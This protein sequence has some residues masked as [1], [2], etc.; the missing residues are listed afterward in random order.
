MPHQKK[1]VMHLNPSG[2]FTRLK[3]SKKSTAVAP[4]LLYQDESKHHT[5]KMLFLVGGLE[6]I[7]ENNA[8]SKFG[9]EKLVH[10]IGKFRNSSNTIKYPI[11]SAFM[12]CVISISHGNGAQ[13]NGFSI[14][15]HLLDVHGCSLKEDT[16]EALRVDKDA[17][18]CHPSLGAK[19][20]ILEKEATRKREEERKRKDKGR[21]EE[22]KKEL[23]KDL[24]T[25]KAAL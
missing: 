5:G 2:G 19:S 11:F 17:I 24:E 7:S 14:N 12:K 16:V 15:K 9:I 1:Y 8:V 3:K 6:N 23:A 20:L 13:E 18:F 21:E 25:V 4:L 10:H 22:S